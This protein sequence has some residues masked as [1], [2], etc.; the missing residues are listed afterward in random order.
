VV[1]RGVFDYVPGLH[2][3][4]DGNVEL[5]LGETFASA[6]F[7]HL[8]MATGALTRRA[9]LPVLSPIGVSFSNDGLRITI[10]SETPTLDAWV[11]R[12]D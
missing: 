1:A 5:A 6:A 8:D 9:N 3:L 11:L 10:R 12:W 4:P 2:W 7:Y